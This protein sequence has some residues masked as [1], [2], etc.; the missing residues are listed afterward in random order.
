[1]KRWMI[2]P[3]LTHITKI[4]F[5]GSKTSTP[6][7]SGWNSCLFPVGQVLLSP[8]SAGSMYWDSSSEMSVTISLTLSL[9][10]SVSGYFIQ[11]Y[12]PAQASGILAERLT[13]WLILIKIQFRSPVNVF[14]YF[15]PLRAS[16][17]LYP[18]VSLPLY[19]LPYFNI[20]NLIQTPQNWT[21][22]SL[23]G[24]SVFIC[25]DVGW[26]GR[27]GGA[28]A[29][30]TLGSRE[31]RASWA[32]RHWRFHPDHPEGPCEGEQ[33]ISLHLRGRGHLPAPSGLF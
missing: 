19:P 18:R 4:I 30:S 29:G 5:S 13:F 31:P 14:S 20:R 11:I 23:L 3:I 21:V 27:A 8:L 16:V 32:S 7:I 26:Q 6:P 17:L 25:L 1:M 28:R 12:S 10:F 9:V 2:I 15:Y 24:E 22:I 33:P